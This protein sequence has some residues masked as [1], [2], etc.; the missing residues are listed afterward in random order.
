MGTQTRRLGGQ[1]FAPQ[2]LAIWG[3][4]ILC[5]GAG[6]CIAGVLAASLASTHSTHFPVVTDKRLLITA[7]APCGQRESRVESTTTSV[8][9]LE[10]EN[11]AP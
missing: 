3:R 6:L 9:G 4:M 5:G 11:L 10:G 2:H 1:G 7:S 8:S